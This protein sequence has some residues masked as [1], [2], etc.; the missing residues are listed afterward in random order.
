MAGTKKWEEVKKGKRRVAEMK[1]KE[2]ARG[3]RTEVGRA[4][5]RVQRAYGA[6]C[7][8]VRKGG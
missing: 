3:E 7:E 8:I 5:G 1:E 6:V 4:I 2:R